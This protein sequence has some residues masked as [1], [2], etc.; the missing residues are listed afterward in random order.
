MAEYID[1]QELIENLNKF[2]PEHYSALVNTL[3]T[4]Q[5]AADVV[6]VKHGK[7]EKVRRTNIWGNKVDILCCSECNSFKY[8]G[9]G[10]TVEYPYCPVCGVKMDGEDNER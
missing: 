7:W 3:I 1:R 6:E 2:A 9:H 4:K 10:I 8:N 5:P